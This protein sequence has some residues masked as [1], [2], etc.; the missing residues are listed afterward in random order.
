MEYTGMV[1][2]STGSWYHVLHDD[3]V[4]R[5]KIKGNFRVKGIV[6]TNPV[7]VGDKVDFLIKKEENTGLITKIHERKNYIIRK[8]INL[9]RK[10]HIIATN[11]DLAVLIITLKLPETHPIFI[12]RFLV[13]AEAYDIPIHLVFNKIDLYG[14]SEIK[15]MDEWIA[16]YEKIGYPSLKVS[17]KE[18]MNL[19]EFKAILKDKSSVISGNSGVGKTTLINAIDPNLSLKTG[20]ISEYHKKG[21]HTTTFSEVFQLQFGGFI[22]DTPGIKGFGLVDLEEENLATYFPEMLALQNDCKYYNCTHTHEPGCKVV[23]AVKADEIAESRYKSYLSMLFEDSG[24]YR[25]DAYK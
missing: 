20:E 22:I 5:C 10:A 25:N 1:I 3:K 12:D 14:E 23:E 17:A 4:T 6:S 16:I 15:M 18:R 9:S 7:A 13:S 8:S 24:K 11:V 2:K 21:K 19:E